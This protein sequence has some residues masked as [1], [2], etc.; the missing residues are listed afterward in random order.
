MIWVEENRIVCYNLHHKI[1]YNRCN[2]NCNL[3]EDFVDKN[4]FRNKVVG[5]NLKYGLVYETSSMFLYHR[6]EK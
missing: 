4:N 6:K 2:I 5:L 1:Y 3:V